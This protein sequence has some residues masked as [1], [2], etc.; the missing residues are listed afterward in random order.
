MKHLIAIAA[1]LGYEALERRGIL[2]MA[3]LTFRSAE[4]V[5]PALTCVAQA[6]FRTAAPPCDHGMVSNGYFSRTLQKPSFWEQSAALVSG[7][8]IWD[9]MRNDGA[10]VGMYFWQQSLGESVDFVLSPAPIHKHGGGMIMRSYTQPAE[11]GDVL[12]R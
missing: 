11:M 7:P 12:D 6:T 8:R 5:F 2:D 4:S 3:G 10:K 9:A 1:G